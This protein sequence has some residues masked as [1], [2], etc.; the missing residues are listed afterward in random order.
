MEFV[1][2]VTTRRMTRAFSEEPVS[3][4]TIASLISLASHAPSA[5]K[6]QGWS[7]LI[8]QGEDKKLFWSMALTNEKRANFAW[9]HLLDA[10]VIILPFADADAYVERYGESD[11]SHTGLGSSK[12]DWPTPYW[13]IDASFA[14]MTILLGANDVG[15]GALFF[16]LFHGATEIREQF[17]VPTHLQSLGAI[18]IGWPLTDASSVLSPREGR[19]A[20]R[21]RRSVEEIAHF[22][23]W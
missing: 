20:K 5:G 18:A 23:R 14:V 4:E 16:A 19:S 3:R 7:A 2:A 8:L 9:P 21:K 17:A 10:P 6:T 12:D 11:K 1:R 13:T 15:L 22:G